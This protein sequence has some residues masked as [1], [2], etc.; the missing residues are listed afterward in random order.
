[1]GQPVDGGVEHPDVHEQPVDHAVEVVEHPAPDERRHQHRRG[2]GHDHRP[3]HQPAPREA[4]VQQLGQAEGDQDRDGDD[5]DDPHDG[6]QQHSGQVT[7]GEQVGVVAQ[8]RES[9]GQS[10]GA[11]LRQGRTDHLDDRPDDHGQDE[12][13]CWTEPQQ[14][15]QRAPV[16]AT[17]ARRGRRRRLRGRVF[18]PGGACGDIVYGHR[19]QSPFCAVF[20][21][22][23][24]TFAGSPPAT[25][26]PMR[27]FTAPSTAAHAGSSVGANSALERASTNG[28]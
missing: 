8:A 10:G 13:G 21:I 27:C 20:W 4:G 28:L 16:P 9:L 26:V 15:L 14:G 24:R 1:M 7:L 17:A 11:H 23:P 25:P 2:P 12:E 18:G 3:P 19:S 5:P 22:S 6:A